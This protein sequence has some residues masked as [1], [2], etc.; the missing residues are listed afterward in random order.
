[1]KCCSAKWTTKHS[2]VIYF[3]FFLSFRLYF[4]FCEVSTGPVADACFLLLGGPLLP[5]DAVH[6]HEFS[7]ISILSPAYRN[8]THNSHIIELCLWTH[9][10]VSQGLLIH[11]RAF[12]EVKPGCYVDL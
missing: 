5:H 9:K 2:I 11:R 10:K 6:E 1:M 7:G 12:G 3:Y 8:H 4:R